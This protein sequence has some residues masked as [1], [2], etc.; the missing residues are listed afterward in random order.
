MQDDWRR[1]E[2]SFGPITIQERLDLVFAGVLARG[3]GKP[4]KDFLPQWRST[5]TWTSDDEIVRRLEA[6]AKPK[7]AK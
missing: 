4:I 7:G 5:A 1:F 2:E 6:M 3:S